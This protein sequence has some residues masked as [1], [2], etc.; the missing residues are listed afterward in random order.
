VG[1]PQALRVAIRNGEPIPGRLPQRRR[2]P[3]VSRPPD[4][5]A[6]VPRDP[7]PFD[8]KPAG[9][10]TGTPMH[11]AGAN[12]LVV[13]EFPD[14]RGSTILL[15]RR[16]QDEAEERVPRVKCSR[17]PWYNG[18]GDGPTPCTKAGPS[19]LGGNLPPT[20]TPDTLSTGV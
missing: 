2:R 8:V 1:L 13:D 6:D 4:V 14:G 18:N 15:L 12:W 7:R 11:Y 3:Q 5:A 10:Y 17:P 19:I 16:Y 20:A 9:R